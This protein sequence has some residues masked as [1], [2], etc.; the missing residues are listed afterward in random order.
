MRARENF[1][2]MRDLKLLID[3]LR[4]AALNLDRDLAREVLKRSVAEYAPMNGIE[5]LVWARQNCDD[6]SPSDKVIN[7]TTRLG[8]NT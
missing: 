2:S 4:A 1:I 3:E 6:V 8:G 5:D 7:I